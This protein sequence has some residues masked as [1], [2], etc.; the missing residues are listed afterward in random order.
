MATP[1]RYGTLAK[2]RG[3]ELRASVAASAAG[4]SMGGKRI[5]Q[6]AFFPEHSVSAPMAISVT[7]SS[8]VSRVVMFVLNAEALPF[9]RPVH[10]SPQC[11][12]FTIRSDARLRI[13]G[14]RPTASHWYIGIFFE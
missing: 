11:S 10:F 9:E 3:S 6:A 8:T 12:G 14:N 2:S 7:N 5:A 4:C 13:V 1:R